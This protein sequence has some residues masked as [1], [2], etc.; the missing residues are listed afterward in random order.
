MPWRREQFKPVME[1]APDE[2]EQI[3]RYVEEEK[4]GVQRTCLVKVPCRE[5]NKRQLDPRI[6]NL[7]SLLEQGITI[8]PGQVKDMLDLTDPAEIEQYNNQYVQQAYDFLVEH[9]DEI[10]KDES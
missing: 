2:W 9:K 8:E 6:V 5:V 4:N 7:D 10:F 1:I 3:E